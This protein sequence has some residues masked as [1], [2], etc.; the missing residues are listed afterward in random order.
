MANLDSTS[1]FKI[2]NLFKNFGKIAAISNLNLSLPENSIL[3]VLGPNGSGKST[4][5][6]MISGLLPFDKG[7]I[8]FKNEKIQKYQTK[9]GYCPQTPVFWKNLKAI[10]QLEF[11]A[12]LYKIPKKIANQQIEYLTDILKLQEKIYTYTEHLS[13][14][15][16]QR[17]NIA[18]S[19]I[20]Q[21]K[22][23]LFDEPTAN[24]DFESKIYVNQLIQSLSKKNN[25]TILL[26]THEFAEIES[27]IT[28]MII[29]KNGV[30]Q[31]FQ[32]FASNDAEQN[33]VKKLFLEHTNQN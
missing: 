20:H 19:I 21:P 13:G 3:G 5:F 2:E 18:V 24:L 14:G 11:Y 4:L 7:K 22:I 23:L 25:L 27:L 6:K 30:N 16:K 26:S 1:L 15:M 9:I 17:L 33:Q 31:Y 8:T 12:D 29:L 10:E 32:T 28:H